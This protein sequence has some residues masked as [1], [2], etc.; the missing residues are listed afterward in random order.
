MP[1]PPAIMN[2]AAKPPGANAP[3]MPGSPGGTPPGPG[4]SPV[5]SPG[6]GAG[7]AAAAKGVVGQ[8][9]KL[10]VNSLAAF[11]FNS[12][13]FKA[14]NEALTKLS[15]HFGKQEDESLVPATIQQLAGAAKSGSPAL[16]SIAPPLAAAPQS[17]PPPAMAA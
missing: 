17:G 11:P 12:P 16:Q 8:A 1:V 9:V 3:V 4:G 2:A 6:A 10:L 7:N 5:M 15:A 13:E 14:V